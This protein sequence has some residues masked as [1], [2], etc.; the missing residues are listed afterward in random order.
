MAEAEKMLKD[1]GFVV[2]VNYVENPEKTNGMVIEQSNS[3]ELVRYGDTITLTVVR[4]MESA[5][6]I[7]PDILNLTDIEEAKKRITDAG[8]K[9]GEIKE[10]VVNNITKAGVTYQS[11]EAGREYV[12]VV[13]G[14]L[15]NVYI[16]FHINVYKPSY[17]CVYEYETPDNTVTNMFLIVYDAK[18][19]ELKHFTYNSTN[20]A[21]CELDGDEGEVF[22][23]ELYVNDQL[24]DKETLVTQ[25][26]QGE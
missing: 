26:V 3:T 8:F 11:I 13:G 17:K 25:L 21:I 1:Q 20:K 15:P 2:K 5:T 6:A 24:V 12:Y 16:D 10:V 18:G 14:E 19:N 23:F 7:V 22:V 4:N 9:V